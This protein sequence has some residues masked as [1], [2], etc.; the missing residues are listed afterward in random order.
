MR[1]STE[2]SIKRLHVSILNL[3]AIIQ[4]SQ[5]CSCWRKSIRIA[6]RCSCSVPDQGKICVPWYSRLH[7]GSLLNQTGSFRDDL[8]REHVQCTKSNKNGVYIKVRRFDAFNYTPGMH[9]LSLVRKWAGVLPA[10]SDYSVRELCEISHSQRESGT[11]DDKVAI[12]LRM[13]SYV[14]LC[15]QLSSPDWTHK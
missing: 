14:S 1:S 7:F 10:V 13:A 3:T 8:H 11:C 2:F 9:S 5:N 12:M 6:A 4:I 15:F